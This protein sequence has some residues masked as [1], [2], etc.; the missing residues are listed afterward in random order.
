M[1]FSVHL[2]MISSPQPV[3]KYKFRLL[4]ILLFIQMQTLKKKSLVRATHWKAKIFLWALN[5]QFC[6]YTYRVAKCTKMQ[7]SIP[8]KCIL[9]PLP[10]SPM[11]KTDY[12]P[13][14]IDQPA[15]ISD[16]NALMI[17]V[18]ECI[19]FLS[20]KKLISVSIRKFW[21]WLEVEF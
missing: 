20:Y 7:F 4:W 18:A 19:Y 16:P 21:P 15:Y 8:F 10:Y 5:E 12:K 6:V 3:P 14:G 11:W 1:T 9:S 13:L 17:A 2:Q